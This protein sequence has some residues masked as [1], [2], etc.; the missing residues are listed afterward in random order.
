MAY[1]RRRKNV[2]NSQAEQPVPGGARPMEKEVVYGKDDKEVHEQWES[3]TARQS[4]LER[5][6]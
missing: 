3:E 5:E 4:T 1:K 2:N 6:Q